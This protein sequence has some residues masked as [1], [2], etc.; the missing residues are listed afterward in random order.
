M[1]IE[2]ILKIQPSNRELRNAADASRNG[3]WSADHRCLFNYF[4]VDGCG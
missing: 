2:E 3:N 4:D 1:N